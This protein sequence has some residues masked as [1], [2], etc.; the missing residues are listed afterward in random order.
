[1]LFGIFFGAEN[2]LTIDSENAGDLGV[3]DSG[4]VAKP[5]PESFCKGKVFY[6]SN[7]SFINE[8]NDCN[9][10]YIYIFFDMVIWRYI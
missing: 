3:G 7:M 1:M 5:G 10:I 8:S 2:G 9:I 4:V 6:D